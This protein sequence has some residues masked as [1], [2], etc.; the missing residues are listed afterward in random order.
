MKADTIIGAL[1]QKEECGR[2]FLNSISAASKS[3]RC[4]TQ[5][6]THIPLMRTVNLNYQALKK[7]T[8]IQTEII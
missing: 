4:T 1:S 5:A 8:H 3:S 7:H 2:Y 6:R